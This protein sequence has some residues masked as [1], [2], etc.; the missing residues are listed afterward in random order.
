MLSA[1]LLAA[2]P[3]VAFPSQGAKLPAIDAVYLIGAVRK[4]DTNVVVNGKNVAVYRTGAWAT[5][6]KTVAGSNDVTVVS[7][8]GEA[9]SVWFRIAKKPVA[10]P[11]AKPA[12]EKVWKKLEYAADEAKSPP[13]N[14]APREI[15]IVLDPGHGGHDTGAKS[16]HGLCEKHANLLLAERVR[17][18]LEARGYNVLMTREDDTFVPL[19]DRPK[20]AHAN[21]AAA[22]VSIHHNAPP[23][24]RDPNA[25][26]YHAVYSWNAIG[27]ELSAAINSRMAEALGEKLAS[28]GSIHANFAVTRNP[29][30]PSCLVEADFVTSP[31]G[32]ESIWNAER[33]LLM[34]DAIASGIDDWCKGAKKATD[35]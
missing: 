19:Y 10:D 27:E 25:L 20:V 28:N 4:G 23:F 30:I 24:D 21:D 6:V 32:E 29:E 33:R 9:V 22:F 2:A 16:P 5:T 26:R 7:Q 8:S 35:K 18:A 12:P 1:L 34:A 15:T 31:A 17:I 14:K 11:G 13:T 3:V